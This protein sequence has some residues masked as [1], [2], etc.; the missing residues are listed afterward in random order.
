MSRRTTDASDLPTFDICAIG[1][2][3]VEFNQRDP[4]LPVFH[5]GFGGDTSNC[6]IAA[7]RSGA[8]CAYMSQ[9]GDDAFGSALRDLWRAET[10]DDSSVR[11]LPGAGT[12]IYFVTHGPDGH[13]FTYR[14]AGSAAAKMDV[15]DVDIAVIARSR[16][17]H[18]S[19]I[20]LA[21][22]ESA[23]RAAWHAVRVARDHGVRVSLDLNF[24]PRLWRREVALDMLGQVAAEADILFAGHDEIEMLTGIADTPRALGW[25]HGV[26]ARNVALK[27]GARGCVVSDGKI[28]R[29]IQAYR[30]EAVD[31]TG[32]GDCFAGALLSRLATGVS[33][34]EAA[35]YANTAAA[36]STTAWGAVDG[37]PREAEVIATLDAVQ[38]RNSAPTT[39]DS[40]PG[41]SPN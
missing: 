29:S 5:R 41:S 28:S 27:L 13:E 7:A 21:I 14:R 38:R 34:F 17:L 39:A 4:A 6:L 32:A 24:R 22:S 19:G 30:V 2:A 40:R 3:M 33:L 15:A 31:A 11:T 20:S 18:L 26:G 35:D 10:V 1:E 9:L 37:V 12:G 16:W 8:R 25:A 23:S 36:L